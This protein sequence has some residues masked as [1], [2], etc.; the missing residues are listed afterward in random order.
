MDDSTQ[1]AKLNNRPYLILD[2]RPGV[3]YIRG[4][5]ATSV[6]FPLSR[7]SRAVGWE[8]EEMLL[9]KNHPE[10]IIILCDEHEDNSSQFAET[11]IHRGYENIFVLSGGLRLARDKI[12]F[13]LVTTDQ[14]MDIS[15]AVAEFI[16]E[17]LSTFPIPPI[18]MRQANEWW[19][20][21]SQSESNE[22]KVRS[23]ARSMSDCPSKKIWH[24]N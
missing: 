19:A 24:F 5:I 11:L 22:R 6:S 1:A 21:K 13:P 20:V 3:E 23:R 18:S 15:I 17:K 9:Y 7:L 8:C 14:S 10:W 16:H 12:G 4:H 2:I